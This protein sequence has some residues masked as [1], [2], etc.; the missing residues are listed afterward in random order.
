MNQT[1]ARSINTSL[2]AILPVLAVL[3]IGAQ[4]LG[5]T[6][7]AV[8]R[9]GAGHR[10]HLGCVL[11]DLHRRPRAR[12][13]QRARVALH[14]HP[15]QAR[16]PARGRRP[17]HP[18]QAAVLSPASTP[19]GARGGSSSAGRPVRSTAVRGP[20]ARCG[21]ASGRAAADDGA[22]DDDVE[23][24][25]TS[26][27]KAKSG[28]SGP[29]GPDGRRRPRRRARVA[30]PLGPARARVR[31]RAASAAERRSRARAGAPLGALWV[32]PPGTVSRWSPSSVWLL[33][34]AGR[35]CSTT[36]WGACWR[37]TT[38]AGPG[39]PPPTAS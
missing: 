12:R 4:L 35:R 23:A 37:P 14:Q 28:A 19:G 11:L 38:P 20:A 6:T 31:R 22:V 13:L 16:E 10:A 36:W 15:T 24:A 9:P 34:S 21:H 18:R 17:A 7:L 1:L 25:T 32:G 39:P 30:R 29:T 5:A 33:R 2:V 8:L 27:P 26:A 3:V